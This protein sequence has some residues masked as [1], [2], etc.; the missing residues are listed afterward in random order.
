M[1]GLNDCV[2]PASDFSLI[3]HYCII[4]LS[5]LIIIY[6]YVQYKVCN[7]VAS[8][9]SSKYFATCMCIDTRYGS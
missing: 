2:L 6:T 4:C 3:I 8:L 1:G 5:A 7:V 9:C